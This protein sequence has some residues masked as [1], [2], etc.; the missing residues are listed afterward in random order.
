MVYFSFLPVPDCKK[1]WNCGIRSGRCALRGHPAEGPMLNFADWSGDLIEALERKAFT[2]G[3][4]DVYEPGGV[5]RDYLHIFQVHP[6][7]SFLLRKYPVHSCLI[8]LGPALASLLAAL[9]DWKEA[10]RNKMSVIFIQCKNSTQWKFCSYPQVR[11]QAWQPVA[12]ANK[13]REPARDIDSRRS[14]GPLIGVY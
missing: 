7:T 1:P 10:Y 4:L 11:M 14:D 2:D 9:P 8:P 3:R 12:A 5:L 13:R 6:K